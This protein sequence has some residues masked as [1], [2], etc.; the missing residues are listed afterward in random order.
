VAAPIANV[1]VQTF[2]RGRS[3]P[4]NGAYANIQHFLAAQAVADLNSLSLTRVPIFI[5]GR[6][7]A[8]LRRNFP[9]LVHGDA[10]AASAQ[11]FTPARVFL[12]IPECE[13]F[14]GEDAGTGIEKFKP[15][16]HLSQKVTKVARFD[17]F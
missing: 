5:F 2:G 1:Y 7:V 11:A 4:E 16:L 6:T 9:A 14:S 12:P 13:N 8:M 15:E 10:V 17:A 3:H